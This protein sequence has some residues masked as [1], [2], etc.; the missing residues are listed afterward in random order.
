MKMSIQ[1]VISACVS[2]T[3]AREYRVAKSKAARLSV[4]EQFA[5]IDHL[6]A[7]RRRLEASGVLVR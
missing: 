6:I 7:C 3:T 4:T 1:H 2:A 5:T